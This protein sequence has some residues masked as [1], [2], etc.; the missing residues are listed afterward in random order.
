MSDLVVVS[1]SQNLESLQ[2]AKLSDQVLKLQLKMLYFQYFVLIQSK[3]INK[4]D[5]KKGKCKATKRKN[6]SCKNMF[7]TEP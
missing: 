5:F 6:M 1:I 3:V 4:N 7:L 2:T